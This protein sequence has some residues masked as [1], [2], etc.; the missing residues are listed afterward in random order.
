V[1]ESSSDESEVADVRELVLLPYLSLMAGVDMD[2]VHRINQLRTKPPDVTWAQWW[3]ITDRRTNN[4]GYDEG[5]SPT[6]APHVWLVLGLSET[7]TPSPPA[8]TG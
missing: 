2:D 6:L 4:G 5:V 3:W 1:I 8:G 7:P